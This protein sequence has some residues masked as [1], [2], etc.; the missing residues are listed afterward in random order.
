MGLPL[1]IT[2]EVRI[3]SL[4][5]CE[6]IPKLLYSGFNEAGT[7]SV[8]MEYVNGGDLKYHMIE[9][10]FKDPP[11]LNPDESKIYFFIC[12]QKLQKR[13]LEFR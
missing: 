12:F 5:G 4:T 1:A 13:I 3:L 6:Y 11:L 2:L 7:W 8:I 9:N 10:F